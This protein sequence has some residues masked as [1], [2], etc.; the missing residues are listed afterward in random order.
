MEL[1]LT[2]IQEQIKQHTITL[3]QTVTSNMVKKIDERFIRLGEE[4]KQLKKRG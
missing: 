4:N 2:K 1:L 3:M